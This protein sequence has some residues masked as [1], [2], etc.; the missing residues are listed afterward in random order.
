MER[1][2]IEP[3]IDV[4]D[5][6]VNMFLDDNPV[7]KIAPSLTGKMIMYNGIE[8]WF[9]LPRIGLSG[10]VLQ[11]NP[12]VGTYGKNGDSKITSLIVDGG[13]G[14]TVERVNSLLGLTPEFQKI[15]ATYKDKV[16]VTF[17]GVDR[18]NAIIEVDVRDGEYLGEDESNPGVMVRKT[19]PSVHATVTYTGTRK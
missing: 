2:G 4:P 13:G 6:V 9:T 19:L 1:V 12:P 16:T 17:A 5:I 11:T 7:W 14:M 3:A 15:N 8:V 10:V 18:I